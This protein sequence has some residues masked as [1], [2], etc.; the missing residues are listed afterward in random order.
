MNDAALSTKHIRV[1]D[2]P[3]IGCHFDRWDV[4]GRPHLIVPI[5]NI[6]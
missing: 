1:A 6:H 4:E 5:V 2:S 3:M